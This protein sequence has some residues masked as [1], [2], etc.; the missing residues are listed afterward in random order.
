MKVILVTYAQLMRDMLVIAKFLVSRCIRD[1][2]VLV[3]R[4]QQKHVDEVIEASR[5]FTRDTEEKMIEK[6]ETSLRQREQQ[7]D[8]LMERLQKHVLY[9]VSVS[10]VVRHKIQN[11][12]RR[13]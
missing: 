2:C 11:I 5:R 3:W 12:S 7:L 1:R 13:C 10:S 6:M 8:R 4:V 9:Y